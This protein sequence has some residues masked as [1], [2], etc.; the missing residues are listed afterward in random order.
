MSKI[1]D[2][3]R[4]LLNWARWK[5]S[6][7][8]MGGLGYSSPAMFREVRGGQHSAAIPMLGHE[9]ADTD[10]AIAL[11][12]KDVQLT[13]HEVYVAQVTKDVAI[14]RLGVGYD[15]IRR[16]VSQAQCALQR[17]FED[18]AQ[19]LNASREAFEAQARAA[20]K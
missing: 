2:V 13:L 1:A 17:I 19:A 6:E 7:G 16:R 9:A 10:S 5:A 20:K 4:R 12:S 14:A 3:E 11:L 18:R 8:A 15:A